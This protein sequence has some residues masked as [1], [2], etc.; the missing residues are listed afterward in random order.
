VLCILPHGLLHWEERLEEIGSTFD[1]VHGLVQSLRR[2]SLVFISNGALKVLSPIRHFVTDHHPAIEDNVKALEAYFWNLVMTHATQEPGNDGF[3][4]AKKRL[5]PDMGNL[6]SLIQNNIHCQQT[7][8]AIEV[9]LK[10][11]WFSIWTHPS[12]DTLKLVISEAAESLPLHAQC[13]QCLGNILC[14][15][16]NYEEAADVLKKAQDQFVEIGDQLDAAQC[17]QNLGD[18]LYMQSNYEEAA[19]VLKKA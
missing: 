18:I 11:S 4:K 14:M 19:D 12:S 10:M 1:N 17:S 2:T 9:A 8:K 7:T 16:S 3:I 5:E 15:Q 13:S 6:H